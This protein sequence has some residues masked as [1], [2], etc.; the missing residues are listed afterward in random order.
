MS[1]ED[2]KQLIACTKTLKVLYVE[3]NE[4]GRNQ[5]L[6]MFNNYFT[7]ID[8]AVDG[9]E[10]L[11]FYNN[12]FLNTNEFYDVVITDIEMPKMDGICMSRAIYNINKKQKIIVLSAYNDKEY[13]IDLINIGVEGFI[14]KPLSF[15]Q[16]S[17]AFIQVCKN[18]KDD[19]II[20][21]YEGFTYDKFSK[22]LFF[23]TKSINLTTNEYK[24][25]E[26]LIQ[27]NNVINTVED[28]FNYIFYDEPYKE[29]TADTIKGLVKRLRKKLPKDLILY[30]R[31]T[32]YG[33][34]KD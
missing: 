19:N 5:A 1:Q 2:L 15:E 31:T 6:K 32:G 16:V 7:Y 30:N 27:N 11:E 25:I 13:F 4:D 3:D 23:D 24:F 34:N 8:I 28:I 9:E 33:I 14:Q 17:E 21:L 18:I 20:N 26:Y 10:G 29:F 22:E 12:Y